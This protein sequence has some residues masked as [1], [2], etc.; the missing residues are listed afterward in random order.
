MIK[1][2][3]SYTRNGV[4]LSVFNSYFGKG[5]DIFLYNTDGTV[6]TDIVNPEAKPYNYMTLNFSID[7]K[8]LLSMENVPKIQFNCYVKNVLNEEIHYPEVVRRN[9]N[10]LPGRP[11]RSFYGSILIGI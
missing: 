7:L 2:G 4:G 8:A 1:L 11:E 10:S 9:I 3:L 5:G 6:A